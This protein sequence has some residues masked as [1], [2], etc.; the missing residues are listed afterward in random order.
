M[1]SYL[2]RHLDEFFHRN[3]TAPDG[4]PQAWVVFVFQVDEQRAHLRRIRL[5]DS[6]DVAVDCSLDS[7]RLLEDQIN[8]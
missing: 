7:F 5:S 3:V 8:G 1:W 2:A 6:T 4:F